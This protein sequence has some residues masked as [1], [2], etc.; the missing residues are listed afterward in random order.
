MGSLA[1]F[2]LLGFFGMFCHYFKKY[3]KEETSMSL[4]EYMFTNK[5]T[6]LSAI[7]ST[8]V[9]ILGL[10]STGPLELTSHTLALAFLTGYGSDSLLNTE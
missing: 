5:K 1:I 2:L 10:M 8:V 6:T 4:A 9:A 3:A 7:I